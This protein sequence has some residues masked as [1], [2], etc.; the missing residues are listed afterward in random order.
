MRSLS[1]SETHEIGGGQNQPLVAAQEWILG[2]GV[3][4]GFVGI[5][6]IHGYINGEVHPL[7]AQT[8]AAITISG[9][10]GSF[11]GGVACNNSAS[12][13]FFGTVISALTVTFLLN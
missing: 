12:G 6:I 10:I 7:L 1:L 8:V 4:L 3:L 2:G 11:Y 5:N 13:F 9:G